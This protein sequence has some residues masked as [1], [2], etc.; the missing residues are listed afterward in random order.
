MLER[1]QKICAVSITCVLALVVCFFSVDKK[2]SPQDIPVVSVSKPKR[3][4]LP[5][6]LTIPST[7]KEA[8]HV[9]IR[10]RIDGVIKKVYF[11]EGQPVKE[12]EPLIDIDDDLLQTQ[13]RQAE[14]ALEKNKA[15]LVQAEN[16]FKRQA[17]LAKKDMAS[18]SVLDTCQAAVK[19]LKASIQSDQ[20]YIDSLKIQIGYSHIKSPITGIAGFL[21]LD[22]GNFV[23][24]SE[25]VSLVSIK[26][27]DPIEILFELPERFAVEI[28]RLPIK[29]IKIFL[30]DIANIPIK[31]Q[32]DVE[33]FDS[34]VDV[35]SGTMW[36]KISVQNFDFMLRPGMS[37][38]GK[39]Q[40]GEFKD[41]L[42]IPIEALQIG[43]T[44]SFV[45]VLDEKTNTVKKKNVIVKETLE[46][47]VIIDSG[48]SDNEVIITD[49][50]IRLSDG[51]VVKK[52]LSKTEI[53]LSVK[54]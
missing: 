48:I 2:K 11:K 43:Q 54:G 49:G 35:K 24:Q 5:K 12:G 14:A 13:L 50:Q 3:K 25:N 23:R 46:S 1:K 52:N 28:L 19:S 26:K 45:F 53:K 4:T 18:K 27:I 47:V 29:E 42:T 30:S 44:S 21:K 7:F 38:I 40:F 17:N 39:I 8:E 41:V 32:A 33:A 16:E 6:T 22:V 10:S 31:S 20:A 9:A 34:S 36:I 51:V 37:V 15:Q